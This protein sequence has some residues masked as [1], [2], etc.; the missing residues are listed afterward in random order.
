M[1]LSPEREDKQE[2]F[3]L[4]ETEKSWEESFY[5]SAWEPDTLTK[6]EVEKKISEELNY[7]L[8]RHMDVY[9]WNLPYIDEIILEA[10]AF[11]L[12]SNITIC[13]II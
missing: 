8:P 12:S 7:F 4:E 5:E 1:T 2:M 10:L 11:E 9:D 6:T 13:E 3:N